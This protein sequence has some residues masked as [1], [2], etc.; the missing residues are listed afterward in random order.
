MPSTLTNT[1][2]EHLKSEL[3][4]AITERESASVGTI[5]EY[6]CLNNLRSKL[7]RLEV[8]E[9]NLAI[10]KYQ[11]VFIG[12]IGEG[13]TT[14]ICHLFNLVGDFSVQRTIAGKP[15]STTETQE[16][17]ATG[18]GRTTICE[19]VIEA[20]ERTA[21]IVEPYDTDEMTRMIE[22]FCDGLNESGDTGEQKAKA[23]NTTAQP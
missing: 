7:I 22:D 8:I 10:D 12:T 19:V 14:A 9:R 16:L 4:R 20:A 15:R 23:S 13:K 11:L 1:D 3:R 17:L 5:P 2:I 18:S 6:L 21:M